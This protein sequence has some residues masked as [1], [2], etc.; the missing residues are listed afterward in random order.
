M[1]FTVIDVPGNKKVAARSVCLVI[2]FL[3]ILLISQYSEKL[4]RFSDQF[5]AFLPECFSI[6]WVECISAYPF[7]DDADWRV[8]RHNVAYVAILAVLPA[9]LTGWCDHSRPH[10]S[11]G[12]LG[13]GLPLK[14]P[15]TLPGE[16]P[17]DF[18]DHFFDPAGLR[19]TTQLGT[20]SSRM[21][22]RGAHPAIPV[23]FIECNREEDVCRF[24]S[25]VGD[26]RFIGRALEVGIVHVY[27]RIAMT[28]RRQVDEPPS[29][30]NKRRNPVDQDKVAEVIR[31]E[32]RFEAV[33]CV[34][35]RVS[36]QSR[37]GDHNIERLTFCQQCV[38]AG[39]HALQ[40][41]KIE[42]YYFEASTVARSICS[43]LR[44]CSRGLIQIPCR[45]YNLSAPGDQGPRR[46]HAKSSRNTCH[47]DPF[48]LQIHP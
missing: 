19:V 31:P 7:G 32:L 5:F 4:E 10:R 18:F 34:A 24:R 21:N 35:E 6:L 15:L 29:I 14:R 11:R 45:A 41:G 8:V 25:A 12:S 38:G 22:S 26:K 17:I 23:T 1:R 20:Y 33:G 47:Q 42:F 13:N 37:I 9:N 27:V 2:P 39:A 3:L 46:F 30:A 44:G 36:H 48:A 16:L 43:H 40:V 28:G